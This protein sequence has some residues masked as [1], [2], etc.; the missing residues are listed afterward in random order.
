[1]TREHRFGRRGGARASAA[2]SL[3]PEPIVA[4]LDRGKAPIGVGELRLAL[5]L[6]H[7]AV[8]ARAVDLALWV[9]AR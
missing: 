1:M 9:L 6:G 3:V 2:R 5:A 8:E 4:L 7:R